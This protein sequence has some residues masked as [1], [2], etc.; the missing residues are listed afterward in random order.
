MLALHHS[1]RHVPTAALTERF[2]RLEIDHQLE[3]C[4]LLMGRS[5]GFENGRHAPGARAIEPYASLA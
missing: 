3:L 2:R 5:T 1:A 4:R